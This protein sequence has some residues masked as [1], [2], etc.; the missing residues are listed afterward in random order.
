MQHHHITNTRN[1]V[2]CGFFRQLRR[3]LL[4][5]LLELRKFDLHQFVLGQRQIYGTNETLTQTG[6]ADL[7]HGVQQL[8][9]GFEFADL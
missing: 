6:L 7:E 9:G 2:A 1:E 4:F 3:E 8:R 5:L